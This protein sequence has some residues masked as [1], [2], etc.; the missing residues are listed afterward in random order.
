M[1]FRVFGSW[2]EPAEMVRARSIRWRRKG[3]PG[4]VEE[5][6]VKGDAIV[7]V[8]VWS[9]CRKADECPLFLFPGA[10]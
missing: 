6:K 9:E 1:A 4:R 7:P 10:A 3:L 2:P 5:G 8:G